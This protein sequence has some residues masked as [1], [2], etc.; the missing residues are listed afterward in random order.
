MGGRK[1]PPLK[2]ETLSPVS[3]TVSKGSHSCPNC[4]AVVNQRWP[5]CLACGE[6]LRTVINAARELCRLPPKPWGKVKWRRFYR[7]RLGNPE[8]AADHAGRDRAYDCCVSEWLRQHP[9]LPAEGDLCAHCGLPRGRPGDDSLPYLR[10]TRIGDEPVW[11]HHRCW[12]RWFDQRRTEARR[13][14]AAMGITPNDPQ[15]TT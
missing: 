12:R 4:G 1:F 5:N 3:K 2:L 9:P 13:S 6:A 8:L 10:T 15:P 7:R 11:V 14:I